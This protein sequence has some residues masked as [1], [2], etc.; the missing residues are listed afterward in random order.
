MDAAEDFFGS[1]F[2]PLQV[3]LDTY[4]DGWSYLGRS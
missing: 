4:R 3:L 1:A 2:T